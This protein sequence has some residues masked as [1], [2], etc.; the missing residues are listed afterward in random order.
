[1][2]PSQ[3]D[4]LFRDLFFCCAALAALEL[5]AAY[6]F[7]GGSWTWD[8]VVRSSAAGPFIFAA[9]L[10]LLGIGNRLLWKLESPTGD[11]DL[12]TYWTYCAVLMALCLICPNLDTAQ[13]IFPFAAL[14]TT[15]LGLVGAALG[16]LPDG[17]A[18][19]LCCGVT[20]ALSA[21]EAL[22]HHW[23]LRRRGAQS[24]VAAEGGN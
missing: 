4:R 3:R 5:A 24:S 16:A 17:A 13:A 18:Y 1:M 6:Q 15:P 7:G 8:W 21:S 9:G 2:N 12:R 14:L 19:P 22:Y 10:L 23:L 11:R 20:L